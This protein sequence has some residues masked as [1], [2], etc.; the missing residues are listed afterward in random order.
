MEE[1]ARATQEVEE[2]AGEDLL[3]Q[4]GLGVQPAAA[5]QEVEEGVREDLAARVGLGS[6]RLQWWRRW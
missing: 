2:E 6:G 5:T 3:V 4:V 1:G